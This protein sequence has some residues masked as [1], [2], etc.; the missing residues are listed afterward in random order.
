MW[1]CLNSALL[2]CHLMNK[3]INTSKDH[4]QWNSTIIYD[5]LKSCDRADLFA[6]ERLFGE[7]SVNQSCKAGST[8]RSCSRAHL[9]GSLTAGK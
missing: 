7:Q 3:I 9:I 1:K 8:N 2:L 5:V 4:Q 6:L